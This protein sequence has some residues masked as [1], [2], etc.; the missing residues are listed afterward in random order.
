MASIIQ[1]VAAM[2]TT[3]FV[4]RVTGDAGY[5]SILALGPDKG[6]RTQKFYDTPEAAIHAALNFDSNERDAY[7]AL[8]RFATA[9]SREAG[10]VTSMG[11]FFLDL[12]CGAGKDYP[13]QGEALLSLRGFVK[14]LKLPKP[15]IV[16]SGRGLHVYWP[17]TSAVPYASWLPVA[18]RFKSVCKTLGFRCD[19]TAT[20]DAARVLRM[21]GTRNYKDTPPNPVTILAN[22]D[23]EATSLELFNA[24]IAPHA[25]V[26]A[27]AGLFADPTVKVSAAATAVVGTSAVM[28]AL[29]GNIEASFKKI[30]RRTAAGTG[31]AQIGAMLSDP[32]TVP[33]PLW[34]AGLS[35]AAHCAEPQA[36]HWLSAGHPDYDADDT[37]HKASHIKGPY[38]CVRFDE[39]NPGGCEGCPHWGKVKSPIVLGNSLIQTEGPVEVLEAPEGA[40]LVVE[41]RGD[42]KMVLPPLPYPYKRGIGGGVYLETK[43]A[44]GVVDSKLVWLHDIYVLR[45]LV[46]P[47]QGEVIEMRYHLPQ[48]KA[49]T[50]VVPLYAV[51]SKEEFRRALAMQGVAAINKEVDALMQYT[52]TWVRELQYRSQADNAHRQFGWVGEFNGFVLGEQVIQSDRIEHNAPAAGTR[53][54]TEFF[55][56]KGTLEGWKETMAFYNRPGFELHQLVVCAGFGSALM[57]FLPESAALIHLWSKDSGFGKTTAKLAA[58]SIWGNPK[59]LI[60]DERDTHNSRMN[61]ADVMHSIPVCMDEVT[62]IRPDHASDLIYQVTGGQQRNRMSSSGNSERFRGDPWNLLFI[63]SG[64]ASLIDKVA[65]AKAMPKAEAQRVLEIEVGRLFS[66][67]SD[68]EDTDKFSRDLLL[69]YGHAGVPFVQYVLQNLQEVQILVQTVQRQIDTTANLGPENRFWSSAMAASIAAAVICNHL[70]LLQYNV[71]TL[72]DYV[73][74]KVLRPNQQASGELTIDAVA[75]V[76]EYV[77][78]NWGRILQ[79]KSTIDLRARGTSTTMEHMAVPEQ[80]PRSTDFA[81]RYETDLKQLYLLIRPFKEWLS[82]QQINYASV[83]D[84]LTKKVKAEKVRVRLSKGTSMSLPPVD[85]L[86]IPMHFEAPHDSSDPT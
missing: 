51:T 80:M 33:E 66:Q 55:T 11:S 53:G 5:Y 76:N 34:R 10:N 74:A 59:K 42:G 19:T 40:K 62:N 52:Q 28:D 58:L 64:N 83:Q 15:I 30:A 18:T 31:C 46:D 35:I 7:F 3:D 78:E 4:R 8:G 29:R 36:I 14:K 73:I 38:L 43:D 26:S 54:L 45:R 22:G 82:E 63:T 41:V 70:G 81:G 12:D 85:V 25:A 32:T 86:K 72:R 47:E 21:P 9:D 69:H 79:I 56:P 13:N 67:K 48:D 71:K 44:E 60:L 77:Y 84:E 16:N 49:R 37:A 23:H 24:C 27:P 57:K 17:L 50:F 2:E 75:L 65:S 39:L 6:K 20:A 68:K 61:R 1:R